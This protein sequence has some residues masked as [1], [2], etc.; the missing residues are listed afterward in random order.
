MVDPIVRKGYRFKGHAKVLTNGDLHAEVVD[1]FRRERGTDPQ[2]VHAVVLVRVASAAPLVSPAYD[3][4][5]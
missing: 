2:R 3:S 5:G 4:G 1:Y